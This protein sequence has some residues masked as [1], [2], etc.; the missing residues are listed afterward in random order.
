[1]NKQADS[2]RFISGITARMIKSWIKMEE[3]RDIPGTPLTKPLSSCTV[4][5]LSSGA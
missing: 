3:P 2:F 4:S 1:M 5:L